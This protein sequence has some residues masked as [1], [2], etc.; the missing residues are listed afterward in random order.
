M[1]L[2]FYSFVNGDW[3]RTSILELNS[4]LYLAGV[5]GVPKH[6]RNLG[7]QKSQL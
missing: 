4:A 5:L 2:K 1:L 7:V 3:T 6:P